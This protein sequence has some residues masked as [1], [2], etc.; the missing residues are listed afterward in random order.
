MDVKDGQIFEN[1]IKQKQKHTDHLWQSQVD[2]SMIQYYKL[3]HNLDCAIKA[4]AKV[5]QSSSLPSMHNYTHPNQPG[6]DLMMIG[7][8]WIVC[9]LLCFSSCLLNET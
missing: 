5:L 7:D 1:R 8:W 2:N 6:I 9:V 4:K 3:Q